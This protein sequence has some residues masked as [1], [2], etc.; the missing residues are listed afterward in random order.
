M[1]RR[2]LANSIDWWTTT[3]APR[4]LFDTP[5]PD[6]EWLRATFGVDPAILAAEKGLTERT[7]R[8]RQRQLGLRKCSFSR[9]GR[10]PA[11]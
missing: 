4:N 9:R 7:V 8:A 5:C 6:S 11:E 2:D 10:Q 1:P 3:R